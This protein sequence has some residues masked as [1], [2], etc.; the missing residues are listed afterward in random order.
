MNQQ[1]KNY[2]MNRVDSILEK[3]TSKISREKFKTKAKELNN[4]QMIE[5]IRSGKVKL[6]SK[7]KIIKMRSWDTDSI[8]HV[9][10]FSKYIT[11]EIFDHEGY[12]KKINPYVKEAQKIKDQLMLGDAEE[13]IRLINKFEKM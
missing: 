7:D 11:K 4:L 1:Q 12:N 9:F 10:D 6:K 5:L 8:K 2:A 13:A 3:K